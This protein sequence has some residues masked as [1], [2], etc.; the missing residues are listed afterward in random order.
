M[1]P[2]ILLPRYSF[3]EELAN[4]I[5]HGLGFLLAI[6]GLVVL[7]IAANR[8]GDAWHI[9]S[10]SVFGAT[11]V[12]LYGSS[13]LYH[14][15]QKRKNK[16]K[17]QLLD[18]SAIFLLIAGTYTPIT[19]VSL[20]GP[21]GW[22]LFGV[23]WGLAFIGVFM[24]IAMPRPWRV[25]SLFLYVGMGWLVVVAA[26]VVIESIPTMGLVL[27]ACGGLAYTLGVIFYVW[28][29]LPFNHAIWHVFVM[30]GSA[31]HFFAVLYFV[32]P[33]A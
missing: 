28:E 25:A 1:P 5:T 15:I 22:S 9:V 7:V 4:V 32:I 16:R 26:K 2:R 13:T 14:T 27:L 17:M 8:F 23:V 6:V 3:R 30:A 19:L 24:R 33:V 20:R 21:W 29:K 31:A 18:H 11:M 12:F 10:C